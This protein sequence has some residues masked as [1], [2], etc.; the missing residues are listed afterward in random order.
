MSNQ[1]I[2]TLFRDV[3]ASYTIKDENKYRFQIIAYQNAADIVKNL[4]F[5]LE[6]AYRTGRLENLPGIGHT[7]KSR[8][9]E[10][11][12][13][14]KVKRFDLV[15]KNIPPS[16]F[17][18][19]N[20]PSFGPKKAYR[21]AVEFNLNEPK[22]V[23]SQLEQL[24]IKNKIASLSGFGEKSQS[25]I[26]KTIKEYRQ[27]AGKL[28]RMN[29]PYA[30]DSAG[31][32][33]SY[34]RRLDSVEQIEALG[35]LRRKKETIGDIDLAVATSSPKKVLDYFT[36]YEEIKRII[37]KGDT[38]ASIL[39]SGSVQI[40]LMTQPMKNF[41]SL[42][43]HL[44]GS[45]NHNIKLRE[46]ALKKGFSLS[47][48]GVKKKIN[49]KL[50]LTSY[51]SEEEFY[52]ALGLDWI[53][54]EIREDTGEIELSV[55]HKLPKLIEASDIK[56]DLHIH[57]SFSVEPSHD[58]GTSSIEEVLE[59]AKQL[60]YEY[61]GFSE[62]N[63]SVSKHNSDQVYNIL[64]K[65]EKYI[66][67][68]IKSNNN[69]RIFKL[70]EV[71]ILSNGEIAIDD[72]SLDILDGIIVSIHSSF[73]QSK[74][75]MTK[76]ILSALSIPKAKILGHPTGRLLNERQP[77]EIDWDMIFDYCKRNNKAIEINSW[78][79]RLDPPD[80]IIRQGINYG[81]KFIINSDSHALWQMDLLKYGV[82]MARRGWAT[83]ND[84]L[85]TLSYNEFYKWLKGGDNKC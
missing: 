19:L 50:T 37:E 8:L 32:I 59:K 16:V 27:S 80:S 68:K 67:Q 41:G 77:Y 64:R 34:M 44:T 24:A 42:L 65:R 71:D 47:E 70:L 62:H 72:K 46:I 51:Q 63:P 82:F 54:P 15:K 78:P 20:I 58:S 57:S 81:V 2:A 74:E 18:L 7:I 45:K 14:G 5:D 61:V 35:S 29:L 3:A 56:G 36:K 9:E 28:K 13:T 43:Q 38:T 31:K 17:E 55:K 85:N 49:E 1:Q 21:L 69:V 48:Y 33:I 73:S 26:L 6:E 83:K 39:V 60:G 10:L 23:V 53:P 12:K 30:M 76:R 11:F 40:D 4:T 75:T 25:G 52:K 79:S 84:I 66:E 22:N